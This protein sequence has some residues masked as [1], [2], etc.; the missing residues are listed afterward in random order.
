MIGSYIVYK[1][2]VEKGSELMN[3]QLCLLGNGDKLKN[4]VQKDS[5][6]AQFDVIEIT[7]SLARKFL[8]RFQCNKIKGAYLRSGTNNQDVYVRL[9][10]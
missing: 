1:V 6:T 5:Q 9:P 2:E 4:V 8:F 7:L 3:T 10:K